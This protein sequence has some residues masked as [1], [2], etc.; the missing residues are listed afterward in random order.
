MAK[1]LIVNGSPRPKGDTAVLIEA[2]KK[3][4]SGEVVEINAF[5]SSIAPC[6]DCR[7]CWKTA[8]CVVRDGMDT[9]YADD[10]DGV[11][12]ASPVWYMTLPGPVLSLMSRF[13]PQHAAMFFLGQPTGIRPKRGALILT[14]GGAKDN[15]EGAL[16]HARVIFKMMNAQGWEE[17]SAMS[18]K[19]DFLPAAEDKKALADAAGLARWLESADKENE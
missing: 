10:F 4:L 17:H 7:G 3:E 5:R 18:L 8:K 1:T 19:T 15:W 12:L 14:A 6:V 11:V 16:H 13:Q 2:L 9:I